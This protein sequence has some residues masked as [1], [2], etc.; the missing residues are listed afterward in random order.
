MRTKSLLS[1][2]GALLICSLARAEISHFP[3]TYDL[4]NVKWSISMDEQARTITGDVVNTVRPLAATSSITFDCAKLDVSKVRVDGQSANFTTE[5]DLLTVTLPHPAAKGQVLNIETFYSGE[6]QAGIYFIPAKRAFPAHTGM[7][8]TQGEMIDTRYWLPTYDWPDNKATF[9]GYIEVPKGEYVLGNGYLAGVEHKGDKDVFH[10]KL[11]QPQSTYLISFVAGKYF[12]GKDNGG[13]IPTFYYVPEGLDEWGE[14]AFGGTSKVVDFYGRLTGFKYPYTK[15]SQ[16]AVGDYMFGGMENTTCVTQTIKALYPKRT[17]PNKDATELVAHELAHQWFGDT[18]TCESWKHAWLNEGFAS[19]LPLFWVREK[20]GEEAFDLERLDTF[21][22]GYSAQ[23]NLH[24]AV[25]W[26]K[27]DQPIDLFD[28]VLYPGG[29]SRLMMMM[30]K[31]GEQPFWKGMQAYLEQ[32]KYQ[33]VNTDE[34]IAA[35]SKSSGVD[36]TQFED[37]WL[38]NREIPSLTVTAEGND[39]IVRQP[40]K[41]FDFPLDVWIRNGNSWEKRTMEIDHEENRLDMSGFVGKPVLVDPLV[42]CMV[43]V[44]YQLNYAPETWITLYKNAPNAAQKQRL[45]DSGFDKLSSQQLLELAKS[46]KSFRL[47]NSMFDK[48][49]LSQGAF[50]LEETKNLEPRVVQA[51]INGM[52]RLVNDNASAKTPAAI[53]WSAACTVRM[54]E[55]WEGSTNDEIRESALETLVAMT[56]DEGTVNKAWNT[57]SYN[58]G[59]RSFA[60]R[61]WADNKP[62]T[63]REKCLEVLG[64]PPSEPVRITAI[65]VLGG[66]KDKP[67]E[68]RAYNALVKVARESSF[69]AKRAAISALGAYGNPAAIRILTPI[70]TNSLHFIRREAQ[71]AID[72]LG[73]KN[74]S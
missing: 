54:R 55:L 25:V 22:G 41:G 45:I 10:W 20:E 37:Q 71:A 51:A 40:T 6:P 59:F 64:N 24:R 4:L 66:V 28:G 50:M 36:L 48:M 70:T 60:L 19:F 46:E 13:Q 42:H 67:G 29:A 26:D 9:D 63:A 72:K 65:N 5:R 52:R 69:G 68:D 11:D 15:F 49:T 33:N 17:E 23:K 34:F 47:L 30:Y 14:A 1:G 43:P 21:Q 62:E 73:G 31:L 53:P 7:V 8:Y 61:W 32:Y 12:E 57:D 2:A 35:M 38:L 56:K 16:A 18:V 39:L 74:A 44:D 3:K 27:V 58:D